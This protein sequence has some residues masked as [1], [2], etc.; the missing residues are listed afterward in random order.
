M[1]MPKPTEAHQKMASLAGCWTGPEHMH[2]SPWDPTGGAATGRAENRMA[3][4]GFALLH[5]YVQERNGAVSFKGHGVLTFDSREQCYSMHW[6][7]SMGLGANI[8]KGSFADNTLTMTRR[9]A[10][11]QSRVV[12]EFPDSRIYRFRMEFSPDGNQ[13]KPLMDGEYMRAS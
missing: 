5:D 11:G 1:E 7:D 6:W 10:Q 9:E 2:P 8:Y 13:W 4:D 3:L 12:W